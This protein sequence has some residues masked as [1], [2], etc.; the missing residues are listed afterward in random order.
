M[1]IIKNEP[2]KNHTSFKIGGNADEFCEP[3]SEEDILSAIEYAN[4]KGIPYTVIGNGSNI[5]VSDKG[6]RGLVIKLS[7]AFSAIELKDNL[8]AAKGGALLSSVALTAQRASLCGMEFASGIPGTMGGAIYMNAG[9]YG[10]TMQDIIKS[11]TYLENGE[12]KKKEASELEWEYR[13][14]LFTDKDAIILSAE[15]E[16]EFGDQ[17]EITE[18]MDD[19]KKRRTEKQPLLMP[20]AGSTFKRPEGYFA[21]KLIED[22]MLKGYSIGGAEVS[23]KHAGFVVNKGNATCQD[24]LDLIKY[25]QDTVFDKFGVRLETEVKTL[26]E[27]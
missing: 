2:M 15:I 26:G 21:G 24:V 18:K 27:F 8:I 11:V 9:A 12:I 7:K 19:Y 4:T 5:L 10:G 3:E 13:K 22:A 23:K 17:K 20:S 6:I 14:S 1:D 16:L 25:V